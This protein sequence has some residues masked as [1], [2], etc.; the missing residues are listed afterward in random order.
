MKRAIRT[1]AIHSMS[2]RPITPTARRYVRIYVKNAGG[3]G[4]T[5]SLSRNSQYVYLLLLARGSSATPAARVAEVCRKSANELC[6]TKFKGKLSPAVYEKASRKL[7]GA[8]DPPTAE[9]YDQ[10]QLPDGVPVELQYVN[11]LQ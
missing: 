5:V 11:K 6:S 1:A 8:F 7:R 10:L 3:K 2:D 4:S 9:A